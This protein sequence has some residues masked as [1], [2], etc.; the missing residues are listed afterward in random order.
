[1]L[2][3]L[4]AAAVAGSYCGI[5]A[6]VLPR[7][8]VVPV[9]VLV[10]ATIAGV[11]LLRAWQLREGGPAIASL[12]GARYVDPSRCTPPE[13]R[14][15]NVVEEMAIAS[16]IAVPPVYLLERE[17]AV[18]ALVAGT[19][20]NEAAII[21]TK[22]ALAKL[23]RDELQAVMGH[24]YSHILNGD[25]ALNL[26]L[27]CVLAGL[28]WLGDRG[29]EMVWEAT[30]RTSAKDEDGSPAALSALLG[31]AIAFIGF[32]GVFAADAIRAAI[33]RQRERLADQ[34]SVQFTRNPD[35]I[36]GALD[37]IL[38]TH[39]H[40]VVHAS[41]AAE[42]SHMFFAPAV[43]H[44]WGF[45]TH[46]PIERRIR[47]AHPRFDRAAYRERRHGTRRELAVI[48][49]S[50]AVVKNV[51]GNLQ[52]APTAQHVD[53]AAQF[54]DGLPGALREALH[55]AAGAQAAMLA[56]AGRA[57]GNELHALAQAVPRQ[58]MLTL[59]ELA[60]PAIKAQPQKVRDAFL[61]ELA[62]AVEADRR[63]TL[64]EFILFT[65]LQQRLREGAGQPI[66]TEFRSI[67]E[68]AADA[69][70]VLSLVAA[71]AGSSAQA[72]YDKGNAFLQ[73]A[74][75]APAKP[76]ALG[77]RSLRESLERLRRLAPLVKPRLVKACLEAAGA[78]GALQVIEV[79]LV[80]M[81]AATLDCPVPPAI[82]AASASPGSSS[83]SA[84]P[85][86]HAD[87]RAQS[88]A[89]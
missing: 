31:A 81:V 16:G 78:D 33:S 73:L 10:L 49:G 71:A 51:S 28:S 30:K 72:A 19:S 18:N 86:R 55:E 11:S 54:L 82:A 61:A 83:A 60:V 88:R 41:H 68:V 22:G 5:A 35:G 58:H 59:A 57:D 84:P 56:L 64:G 45:A 62:A 42:L 76:E 12:L 38:S 15:I 63:V 34:A 27:T 87:P 1:V 20:P 4:A 52:A 74:E 25:M 29:E 2:Y 66:R 79:E 36:A 6:L 48:D 17:D 37:S 44:W 43:S 23:S 53:F 21:V 39:S 7:P 85:P 77:T 3:V 80:R 24:E 40:T 47:L 50:G 32:P 65:Y 14:L 13:R 89:R 8:F 69:H 9:A 70:A 26:R 67:E 46:P 75:P